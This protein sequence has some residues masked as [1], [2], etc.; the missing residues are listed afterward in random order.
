MAKRTKVDP[1]D[2]DIENLLIF[3]IQWPTVVA[4][5]EKEYSLTERRSE[6]KHKRPLHD[7]GKDIDYEFLKSKES[8]YALW[9][10]MELYDDLTIDFQRRHDR[11]MEGTYA[12]VFPAD[13][14][15]LA[16]LPEDLMPSINNLLTLHNGGVMYDELKWMYAVCGTHVRP[17]GFGVAWDV[18][19]HRMVRVTGMKEL[20]NTEERAKWLP[21]DIPVVEL[22]EDDSF[23]E[24]YNVYPCFSVIQSDYKLDAK[25]IKRRYFLLLFNRVACCA[26]HHHKLLSK[27]IK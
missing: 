15:K 24:W 13:I 25:E 19:N 7:L 9:F 16:T 18:E 4:K 21:D 1:E 14:H 27:I 8:G 3:S 17:A 23:K 12:D 10:Y 6:L 20:K 22:T 26:W 11:L 5:F 2:H